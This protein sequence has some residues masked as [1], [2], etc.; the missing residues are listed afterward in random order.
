MATFVAN[1][2]GNL[3]NLL[4]GSAYLPFPRVHRILI[5]KI[6]Q[7]TILAA[8]MLLALAGTLSYLM[9]VVLR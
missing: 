5:V 1:G 3:W 8:V 6:A 4:F 7:V 9:G 2:K